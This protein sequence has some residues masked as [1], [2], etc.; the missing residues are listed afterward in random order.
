VALHLAITDEYGDPIEPLTEDQ[1]E[2]I[3]DALMGYAGNGN[4]LAD[5]LADKLFAAHNAELLALLRVAM[6][7]EDD[8]AE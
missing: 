8:G 2:V 5:K 3:V 4:E 6:C 1:V 7:K